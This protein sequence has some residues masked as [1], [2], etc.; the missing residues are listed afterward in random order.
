MKSV[1]IGTPTNNNYCY[2]VEGKWYAVRKNS[3]G[4]WKSVSYKENLLSTD[5]Y[6]MT[7]EDGFKTK[8][9]CISSLLR[10]ITESPKNFFHYEN[11]NSR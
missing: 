8:K 2:K 9:E 11:N 7:V 3:K 10:R 6:I 4:F 1:K 5:R